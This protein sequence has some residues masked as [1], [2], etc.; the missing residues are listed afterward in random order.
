MVLWT[1]E[2][3]TEIYKCKNHVWSF[4]MCQYQVDPQQKFFERRRLVYDA[5]NRRERRL[6]EIEIGTDKSYY[7]QLILWNEVHVYL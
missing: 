4:T 7:D 2:T 5:T 6:E 3:L 1:I